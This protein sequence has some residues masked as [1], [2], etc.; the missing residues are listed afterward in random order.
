MGPNILLIIL[1]LICVVTDVRE[2]KIYNKVL[3]PTFLIAMSYHFISAGTEG[4]TSSLLGTLTGFAILLIPYLM[5]GMGAG[6][7]KLLAVIGALKGVSFVLMTSVFMA[8][9]GG[10]IGIG[11]ILFRKGVTYRLKQLFYFLVFKRQGVESPFG[12]DKAALQT[13]FPY[14]VAIALGAVIAIY[15]GFGGLFL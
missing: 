8:L 15:S 2:R 4:L 7:V 6:D 3:F 11:I 14:G 12:F 5:G 13:T 9:I 10:I 1:L